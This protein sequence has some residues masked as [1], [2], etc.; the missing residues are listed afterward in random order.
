MLTCK[1]EY[2]CYYLAQLFLCNIYHHSEYNRT[3]HSWSASSFKLRIAI[4]KC[5]H[6]SF[7]C[8]SVMCPLQISDWHLPGMVSPLWTDSVWRTWQSQLPK[9][10][11]SSSSTLSC[12]IAMHGVRIKTHRYIH[13]QTHFWC[14]PVT[15]WYLQLFVWHMLFSTPVE[16]VHR[17]PLV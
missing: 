12:F 6:E 11:T 5:L 4:D 13:T 14:L 1:I 16:H 7:S 2:L 8:I 9:T 15:Y 17:D 10:S 3:W